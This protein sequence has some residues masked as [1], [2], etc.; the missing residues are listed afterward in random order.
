MS[1]VAG[2]GRFAGTVLK[3]RETSM[4]RCIRYDESMACTALEHERLIR[5]IDDAVV[6]GA[7]SMRAA[8]GP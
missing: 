6:A 2:R 3:R 1:T 7:A 8:G 5:A 4:P